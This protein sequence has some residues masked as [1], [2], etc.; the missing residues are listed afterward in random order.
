[1]RWAM[2]NEKASA[3]GIQK[4]EWLESQEIVDDD[5]DEGQCDSIL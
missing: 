4:P 3:V 2:V 1:M 5:D